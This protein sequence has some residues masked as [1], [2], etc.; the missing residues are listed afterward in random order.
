MAVVGSLVTKGSKFEH[1]TEVVIDVVSRRS[2]VGV[3]AN[4]N[5]S[6]Q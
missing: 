5:N 4:K 1:Q 3:S 6:S 2:P